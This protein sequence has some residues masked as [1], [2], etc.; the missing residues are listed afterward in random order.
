LSFRLPTLGGTQS[1][2]SKEDKYLGVIIDS[3]LSWKRN[4]E[5]RMKKALQA[6]FICK[7]TFEKRWGLQP[8]II[9]LFYTAV[10]RPIL[11]Y[12]ALVWWEVT[13]TNCHLLSLDAMQ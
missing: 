9:H 10:V 11:T 5:E 1:K 6:F 7:K 8:Y 2:L 12:G 3:K 13:R 4:S